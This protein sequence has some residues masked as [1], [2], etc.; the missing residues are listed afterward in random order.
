MDRPKNGYQLIR[1]VVP[2]VL[3]IAAG[4]TWPCCPASS[5]DSLLSTDAI[6]LTLRVQQ[7]IRLDTTLALKIE[8]AL[9]TTSNS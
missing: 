5:A 7:G 3:M 6:L 1:I 9:G 4:L 2:A 8:Q